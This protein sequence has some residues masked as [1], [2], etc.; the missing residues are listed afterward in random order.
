MTKTVL[1]SILL[2]IL[3]F[4]S[5]PDRS[6]LAR[7]FNSI[8]TQSSSEAVFSD[9]EAFAESP[10]IEIARIRSGIL[11]GVVVGGH[12]EGLLK[13][14]Q[15]SYVADGQ[16][17]RQMEESLHELLE[18]E[19]SQAGMTVVRSRPSLVFE[20]QLVEDLEPGRFLLG[21]TILQS[22]FNSYSSLLGSSTQDERT[23]RWELFDREAGRV[24]YRQETLGSAAVEG[25]NNPAA[26]YEAIRRSVRA[27]LS[28][29]ELHQILQQSV[30]QE[31]IAPAASYEI[32]AIASSSQTLSIEQIASRAIPS[33]V[34]IRTPVGRGTGFLLNSSGLLLTNQHVV[35]SSFAVQVDFYD[36][37][38]RIGRVLRRDRRTDAALVRLEGETVPVSGLPICHTNAVRVGE[39]VVA[40]G[41]PLSFSNT[42]TQGIISGIRP[43]KNRRLIQTDAAVNPGNSG[44]PLLNRQGTVVG[45]VT[46]KIASE[47][48]EGLSFALSIGEVLERLNV[49]VN[50]PNHEKLNDCGNPMISSSLQDSV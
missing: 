18:E 37:S 13:L 8:S 27:W 30:R 9:S 25:V 26:T 24:V 42:V 10:R 35:G 22:R 41:N 1:W 12:Y 50:I 6:A 43:G 2:S 40:I 47:G 48:V 14:R 32:G 17:G 23:I 3:L 15:E 49:K 44:G 28:Q 5:L 38:T 7:E 31:A 29:P 34:Q 36:G 21:G 45:I 39:S 20:E 4:L 46:Q 19:L 33:T 11:P 16:L